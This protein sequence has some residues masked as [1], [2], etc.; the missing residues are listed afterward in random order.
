MKTTLKEE[1]RGGS[2]SKSHRSAVKSFVMH[3]T[4]LSTCTFLRRYIYRINVHHKGTWRAH[5][6]IIF[7][8]VLGTPYVPYAQLRFISFYN[9]SVQTFLNSK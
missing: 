7:F 3:I 2:A 1:F 5:G 9:I 8:M 4:V 6:F